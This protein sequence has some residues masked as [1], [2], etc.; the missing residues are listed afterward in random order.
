MLVR[1]STSAPWNPGDLH[2]TPNNPH[3]PTVSVHCLAGTSPQRRHNSCQLT[4]N[5]HLHL[6]GHASVGIRLCDSLPAGRVVAEFLICVRVCN[7]TALRSLQPRLQKAQLVCRDFLHLLGASSRWAKHS[8]LQLQA[9]AT[10]MIPNNGQA[11]N[12]D[13]SKQHMHEAISRS[14]ASLQSTKPSRTL[15]ITPHQWKQGPAWHAARGSWYRRHLNRESLS[16]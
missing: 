6:R 1:T 8:L 9:G 4:A 5:V 13:A 16:C 7:G 14:H 12:R 15:H 3:P 11:T 2:P 10:Q